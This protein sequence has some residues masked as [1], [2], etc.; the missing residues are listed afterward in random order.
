MCHVPALQ[1]VPKSSF[2]TEEK[3]ARL[4]TNPVKVHFAEEVLVSAQSQVRLGQGIE[5]A[6]HEAASIAWIGCR[7][8]LLEALCIPSEMQAILERVLSGGPGRGPGRKALG[9]V[10][11]YSVAPSSWP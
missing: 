8:G 7:M 6:L 1:G 9:V 4:K 5:V 11:Y 10:L 2:L 3:R